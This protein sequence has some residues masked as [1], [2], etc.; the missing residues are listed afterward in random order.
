[1]AGTRADDRKEEIRR[2]LE[3]ARIGLFEAIGGL[4]EEQMRRRPGPGCWS[5]AEVMAHLPVWERQV[6]RQADSLRQVAGL[7][8]VF[9]SQAEREEAAGRGRRLPPPGIV[10]DLVAARYETLTFLEGLTARELDRR[11]HHQEE[12]DLTVAR[13]LTAIAE[14]EEEQ[15][16]RIQRLRKELGL[17]VRQAGLPI[18]NAGLPG[19]KTGPALSAPQCKL[20]GR[21]AFT[22][23][24]NPP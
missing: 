24:G 20:S 1:V 9:P 16:V 18:G 19:G 15:V 11:G 8:V 4:T 7:P 17:P 10:H 22:G 14:Y 5:V 6:L 12:G 23:M 13:I 2:R 21:S 3:K